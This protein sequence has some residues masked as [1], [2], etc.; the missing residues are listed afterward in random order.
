MLF[1]F[2]CANEWTG[3]SWKNAKLCEGVVN[4]HDTEIYPK[5]D[6]ASCS[7]YLTW[8]V[9]DT[10]AEIGERPVYIDTILIVLIY[11]IKILSD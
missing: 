8:V 2:C 5:A 4:T 10:G 9:E 7:F 6:G 3:K 1:S 11:N